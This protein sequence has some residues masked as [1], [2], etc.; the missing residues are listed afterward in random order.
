MSINTTSISEAMS[1]KE[2]DP[3]VYIILHGTSATVYTG[4]DI[5]AVD[6]TKPVITLPAHIAKIMLLRVGYLDAVQAVINSLGAEAII[7]FTSAPEINS[8]NALVNLVL[9]EIGYSKEQIYQ[10]FVDASKI[11]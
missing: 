10:L 6:L 5:P 2:S 11:F 9:T 7:S 4:L 1:L 8:D 3:S